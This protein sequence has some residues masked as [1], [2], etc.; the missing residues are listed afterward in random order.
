MKSAYAG[1]QAGRGWRIVEGGNVR[2]PGL[3]FIDEAS[4]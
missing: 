4:V 2:L 3:W 1:R